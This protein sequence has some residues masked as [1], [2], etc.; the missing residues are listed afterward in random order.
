MK[1]LKK[2]A[3][4]ALAAAAATAAPAQAGYEVNGY[5]F[6][7]ATDFNAPQGRIVKALQ[8]LNIP[9]L[10]GGK[11]ELEHC[12]PLEN[13]AYRLGFYVPSHNFM[14]LC[15]NNGDQKRMEQTLTHEAVHVIQDIRGGFHNE[16]IVTNDRGI[17]YFAQHLPQ[18]EVDLIVNLYDREQWPAEI[19]ARALQDNPLAV[20][21]KL[22]QS[23]KHKNYLDSTGQGWK[24]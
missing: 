24:F 22:E 2:F 20:A 11:M 17:N 13:G 16:E 8:E 10:D 18:S 19:E 14:V 1:N 21:D 3:L 15:T 7:D 5:H 6:M 4:T 23:V 12:E 9:V